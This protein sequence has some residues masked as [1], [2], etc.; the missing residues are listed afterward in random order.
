MIWLNARDEVTLKQSFSRLADR[1]LRIYPTIEYLAEAMSTQDLDKMVIS[2]KRWLDKPANS[3][4]LLVYDNYDRPLLG[5][6]KEEM[7]GDNESSAK[8]YDIRLYLPSIDHGAVIITTR[9]SFVDLGMPIPLGMLKD[10]NDGFELLNSAASGR[11]EKGKY[12]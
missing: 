10:A 12:I 9:S 2:V 5:N 4:W 8:P 11:L 7:G 3:R 6:G 1:I